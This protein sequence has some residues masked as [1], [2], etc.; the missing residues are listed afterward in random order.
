[1]QN[2]GKLGPEM[3][4]GCRS[5][6]QWH[7]NSVSAVDQTKPAGLSSL[8]PGRWGPV[9][10]IWINSVRGLFCRSFLGWARLLQT[11]AGVEKLLSTPC[12]QSPKAQIPKCRL[13]LSNVFFHQNSEFIHFSLSLPRAY[14]IYKNKIK[15]RGHLPALTR[16]QVCFGKRLRFKNEGTGAVYIT[17]FS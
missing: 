1:M 12:A 10:A 13:H 14:K 17:R 9:G 6:S 3:P 16:A 2:E 8:D 15:V 4:P 5:M 11:G 7:K